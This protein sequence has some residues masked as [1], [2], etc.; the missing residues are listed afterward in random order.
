MGVC[1]TPVVKVYKEID[2][3]KIT[4]DSSTGLLCDSEKKNGAIVS[5]KV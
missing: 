4:H 1:H 3:D 2:I 5:H